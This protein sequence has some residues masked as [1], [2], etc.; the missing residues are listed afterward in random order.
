MDETKACVIGHITVKDADK[1]AEYRSRVPVTLA[2]WGAQLLLRGENAAVLG[3]S[4]RHQATVV[5]LFPDLAAVNGWY[6]SAA[7]Q[8]L[9]PLREQA[10]DV[11]LI[12]FEV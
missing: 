3:G 11:D 10:A 7:Y 4:H 6:A 1:W 5:I 12:S 9:V 2:P 8:A